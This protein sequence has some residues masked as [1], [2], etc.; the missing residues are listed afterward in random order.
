MT[1][2]NDVNKKVIHCADKSIYKYLL[3]MREMVQ[4]SL[5]EVTWDR[6]GTMEMVPPRT[7]VTEGNLILQHF[8]NIEQ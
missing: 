3:L 8:P 2:L 7:Q 5:P 6:G 1:H 4:N